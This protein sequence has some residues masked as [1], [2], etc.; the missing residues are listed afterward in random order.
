MGQN[1]TIVVVDIKPAMNH[2]DAIDE[3]LVLWLV[4]H[5]KSSTS[6]RMPLPDFFFLGGGGGV[7]NMHAMNN[8][9]A[10]LVCI[11]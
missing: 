2:D 1:L 6:T 7:L 8:P 9:R 3:R 11:P 10:Y 4:S 5:L